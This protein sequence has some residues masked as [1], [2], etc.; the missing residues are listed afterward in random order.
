MLDIRDFGIAD[1]TGV[2][3][4]TPAL[5]NAINAAASAVAGAPNLTTGVDSTVFIPAGTFL[6]TRQIAI[7]SNRRVVP[8][9]P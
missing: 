9:R 4:S 5:Q 6:I 7:P 8:V 3:D 2:Q 1:P